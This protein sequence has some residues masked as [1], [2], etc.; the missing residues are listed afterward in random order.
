MK[1]KNTALTAALT[2]GLLVA[3]SSALAANAQRDEQ[4]GGDITGGGSRIGAAA[5]GT[6]SRAEVRYLNGVNSFS[7]NAKWNKWGQGHAFVQIIENID[8]KGDPIILI[9]TDAD[10][11][12]QDVGDNK[13]KCGTRVDTGSNVSV[14]ASVSGR[15]VKI[16][17]GGGCTFTATAKS[18]NAYIKF[19]SYG[20]KSAKG[21]QTISW[22]SVSPGVSF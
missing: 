5:S 10:G 1:M 6:G 21:S 12:I 17:V 14:K 20:N 9:N 16:T 18:D 4:N 3:A 13:K 11:Y 22:T 7:G 19:G 2:L 15:N 8:G